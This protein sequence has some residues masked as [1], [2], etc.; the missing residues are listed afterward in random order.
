MKFRPARPKFLARCLWLQKCAGLIALAVLLPSGRLTAAD[1]LPVDPLE[2]TWTGTIQAPQGVSEEIGFTFFRTKKGLLTFRLNFPAMFT[3]DAAFGV[4][5]E[6]DGQGHYEMVEAI[7]TH[8]RLE[9][10]RLIGTFAQGKLPL[11]LKRGGS[12]LPKPPAPHY[13]AAPAPVWTYALG[14]P[15]WAP[16]VVQDD[17]VYVGTTDGRFHAVRAADGTE[18]WTWPGPNP[19]DGRAVLD[20]DRVYF[21]DRRVNLVALDRRT[22]SRRW[23]TALHDET[24]AGQPAP[25]NPTFNRR[26]AVPFLLDGVVYA[27]SSDGGLYAVN[28]VTGRTLWRH[29]AKSPIFSGISLRG[30]DTLLFG[31][32]DGSVILLDRQT[33]QELLRLKTG[34]GVVTTPL[35]AGDKLIVGS[36]DYMLY[37]FNLADGSLAWRFSYWFSWVESTPVLDAGVVYVGASDYRRVTALDPATGRPSWGTDVRGAD[38]GSPLVTVDTVFIGTIAQNLP[39]T[40]IDHT[41]GIV[42]LDRRSGAVK[43]QLFAPKPDEGKFGGYAGT[44]ALAGDKI[45]AAGFDGRLIALPVR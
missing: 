32:M 4:P 36:R 25:D 37:G 19:I 44:L 27:G 14:A 6:T 2:G 23:S 11:E 38:W 30:A 9:G 12:F 41:G 39:G 8:L 15:T 13:P 28:A 5:V 26:T 16:P 7:D 1:P 29:D 17:V 31:C 22:G 18:V 3:Y 34:G 45:I 35:V 43:W 42:A 21:I 24:L 20:D 33:R 40:V 10:D